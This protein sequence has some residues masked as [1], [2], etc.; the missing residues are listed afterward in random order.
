MNFTLVV[1]YY[2][3][4]GMLRRQASEW[5]DYPDQVSVVVVDDGSPQDKAEDVLPVTCRAA[6]YRIEVDIPWNRNGARNLGSHVAETQWILHVDVDHVL[7]V[8]SARELVGRTLD[9]AWWYRFRRFRVGRADE[10]RQK[11]SLPADAEYG[12]VKPHIDSFLCRRKLYYEAGGYDEDY[13]G[14]LGGSA[15]FLKRME[16]LVG[17]PSVLPYAPLHVYTRHAVP[18]ASDLH[19]SRDRS[20]FKKLRRRKRDEIPGPSLRFPWHRAR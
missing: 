18:D 5:I 9:P 11:D 2:R 19:L 1:P 10:T 14:S 8:Q 16:S 13:S 7:P 12:E 6:V 15:P 20:R 17:E 4:P 3:N